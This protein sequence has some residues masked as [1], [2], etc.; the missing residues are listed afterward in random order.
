MT[1]LDIIRLIEHV[2]KAQPSIS[3]IVEN[4]VFRL[5]ENPQARYGVFAFTQGIHSAVEGEDMI[6]YNFTLFYVDRLT[7]SRDNEIE[8]QSVGI[9]TLDNIL[10]VLQDYGVGVGT[11]TFQ[12]FNQ[13]F[14]DECS[15]TFCSVTLEVSRH[16][17]CGW[18]MT[19][20]GDKIII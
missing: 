3:S 13:R 15:G 17:V 9:Q 7:E 16:W 18:E 6:R 4:D 14:T 11:Y 5:N 2:A 10:L 12:T 19:D 1:L 20:D 8:V